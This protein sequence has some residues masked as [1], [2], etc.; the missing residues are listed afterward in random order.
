MRA[1]GGQNLEL[2]LKLQRNEERRLDRYFAKKTKQ[3]NRHHIVEDMI[4]VRKAKKRAVSERTKY[5]SLQ[6]IPAKKSKLTRWYETS[7]L[8]RRWDRFV[9][10]LKTKLYSYESI[11]MYVWHTILDAWDYIKS[12][13][14]VYIP[15]AAL[16]VLLIMSGI[17]YQYLTGY[18]I[19]FN[20][21][22]IGPSPI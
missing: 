11:Y 3:Y 17:S 21:Y 9:Y 1:Y 2:N 13:K 20:G 6:K 5:Y 14:V 8:K 16:I 4:E 7:R 12:K 18:E 10:K 15:I 19:T 22:T